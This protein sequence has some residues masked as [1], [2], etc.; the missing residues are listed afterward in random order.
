MVFVLW[1]NLHQLR[2][3]SNLFPHFVFQPFDELVLLCIFLSDF[4]W[5]PKN[6][7][8]NILNFALS[9]L[10]DV[11]VVILFQVDQKQLYHHHYNCFECDLYNFPIFLRKYVGE[12]IWLCELRILHQLRNVFVLPGVYTFMCTF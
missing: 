12:S 3:V 6:K 1:F 7:H 4:Q 11:L 5:F 9:F 8:L 10:L 2:T